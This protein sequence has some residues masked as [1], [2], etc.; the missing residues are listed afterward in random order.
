MQFHCYVARQDAVERDNARARAM[1]C[2]VR[3]RPLSTNGR[4]ELEGVQVIV[5]ADPLAVTG[6]LYVMVMFVSNG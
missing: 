4:L 1:Y 5:Y 2:S 6:S 3:F